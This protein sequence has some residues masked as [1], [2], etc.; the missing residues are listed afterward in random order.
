LSDLQAP[1]PPAG[2]AQTRPQATTGLDVS[3]GL[4]PFAWFSWD[5]PGGA[6]PS[7]K[8]FNLTLV[9]NAQLNGLFN[10]T[11]SASALAALPK[12]SA[13]VFGVCEVDGTT[14]KATAGVLSTYNGVVP[15]P[16]PQTVSG[17]GQFLI[18]GSAANTAL[19]L[20]NTGGVG[21]TALPGTWQWWG[22]C[23]NNTANMFDLGGLGYTIGNISSGGSQIVPALGAN[24]YSRAICYRLA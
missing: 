8:V 2:G 10:G 5:D 14:L 6:W 7:N 17:N 13:S 24:L 20:T 23:Y 3:T 1:Q 19:Y 15:A 12:A 16:L 22:W 11:L 21:G 4:F 9:A 18:L